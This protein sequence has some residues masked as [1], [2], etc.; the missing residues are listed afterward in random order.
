[1]TKPTKLQVILKV[2]A[3]GGSIT[4]LGSE[5]PSGDWSF[6]FERNEAAIADLLSE[7]DLAGFGPEDFYHRSDFVSTFDEALDLIDRYPWHKLWPLEVRPK[8]HDRV[9]AAV[10][11]R[12]GDVERWKDRL[13]RHGR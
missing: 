7:E 6:C 8:F 3:E 13:S 4:I 11:Q 10:K 5:S 2:G 12:G 9:F 1:M